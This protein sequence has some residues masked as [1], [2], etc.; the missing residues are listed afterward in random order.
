MVFSRGLRSRAQSLRYRYMRGIL[1]RIAIEVLCDF[2]SIYL[3]RAIYLFLF[4]FL[5]IYVKVC[6]VSDK[7]TWFALERGEECD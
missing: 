3:S 5:S 4:V 2:R 1:N 6:I 7:L